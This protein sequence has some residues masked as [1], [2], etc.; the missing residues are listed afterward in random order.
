M[1]DGIDYFVHRSSALENFF[2]E[3]IFNTYLGGFV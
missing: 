3:E 2:G 1:V